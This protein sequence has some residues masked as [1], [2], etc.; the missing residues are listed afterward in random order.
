MNER[1]DD[2]PPA[3][4]NATGVWRRGLYPKLDR[5]LDLMQLYAKMKG[6]LPEILMKELLQLQAE[7]HE[8]NTR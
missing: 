8:E 7:L 5:H 4:P 2:V 1:R 3:N 6:K